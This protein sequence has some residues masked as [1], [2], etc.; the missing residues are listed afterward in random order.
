MK[1][2]L[3]K[4]SPYEVASL[5]M[6][7][8]GIVLLPF[9]SKSFKSIPRNKI[10]IVL[11]SGFIGS[12]FPAYLFCIAETKLDSSLTGMLNSFTPL[13]AV[14]L[15]VLFFKLTTSYLKISGI[16]IGLIGLFF[17]VSPKGSFHFQNA[18]Y[19]YLVILATILYAVNVNVVSRQMK[20]IYPIHIAS[21]A[22]SLFII[23]SLLVLNYHQFF[24]KPLLQPSYLKSLAASC[25]LGMVGTAFASVLF[26][27]LVKKAG[28]LF[29]AMV[30]YGIPFIA[31][32]WGFI[33][34]ETVTG[35]EI[36]CL[37][38]ILFG[39]YLANKK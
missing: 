17:L 39:V 32:G 25:F 36:F 20:G 9:V 10:G 8:A 2:G 38:I 21:L 18:S 34:G 23:P 3:E 33:F 6:L 13:C 4:L 11:L 19:V 27:D 30:T 24:S 7:S 29:A 1:I 12:F 28:P 26:Y 14:V 5:R 16:L 22:F 15:G 35:L 37:G 31:V